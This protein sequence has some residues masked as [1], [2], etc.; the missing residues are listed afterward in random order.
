MVVKALILNS[1]YE[2]MSSKSPLSLFTIQFHI[3]LYDAYSLV[4]KHYYRKI[5]IW[6]GES[7]GLVLVR[8]QFYLKKLIL[9][10]HVNPTLHS[11]S[12]VDAPSHFLKAFFANIYGSI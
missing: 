5:V 6:N 3:I 11:W 7:I 4:R 12:I 2:A 1:H 9:D 10:K 8:W